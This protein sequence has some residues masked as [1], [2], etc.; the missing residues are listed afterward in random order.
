MNHLDFYLPKKYLIRLPNSQ[1]TRG[2]AITVS[3]KRRSQLLLAMNVL[4]IVSH[5]ILYCFFHCNKLKIFFSNLKIVITDFFKP[6]F[7]VKI[8]CLSLHF[9]CNALLNELIALIR[10]SRIEEMCCRPAEW[11]MSLLQQLQL[12]VVRVE[13]LR[14]T[15]SN[16]SLTRCFY[17]TTGTLLNSIFQ[18]HY[19]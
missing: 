5:S 14:Q 1:T 3:A 19:Y 15:T 18:N 10:P 4:A 6:A 8:Y 2:V 17:K 7:F 12:V 16:T 13:N 9:K 11:T